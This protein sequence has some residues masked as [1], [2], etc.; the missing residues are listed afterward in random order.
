MQAQFSERRAN[1]THGLPV[2]PATDANFVDLFV[3]LLAVGTYHGRRESA[4]AASRH[5]RRSQQGPRCWQPRQ[6]GGRGVGAATRGVGEGRPAEE[7]NM[8]V[9]LCLDAKRDGL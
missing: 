4:G 3:A 6:A 1:R 7:T 8:S 9:V 2:A 5:P